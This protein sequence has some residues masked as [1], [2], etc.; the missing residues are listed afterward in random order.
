MSATRIK[1][2]DLLGQ[3]EWINSQSPVSIHDQRGRV[4]LLHFTTYSSIVC[5]HVMSDIN[6]LEKRYKD[7]LTVITIHSPKHPRERETNNVIN[8]VSRFNIKHPVINDSNHALWKKFRIKVWPSIIFID[9]EGYIVGVIKGEGRR[10]QLDGLIRQSMMMAEQKELYP[11][12]PLPLNAPPQPESELAFPGRIH[13]TGNRLFISDS[14]HNRVLETDITG[15]IVRAY[16]SENPG[17]L[18]GEGE[19]ALF[20]NPQGIVKLSDYLYVADTDNHA[21][22]RIHLQ[23]GDVTTLMGNGR[24]GIVTNQRFSDPASAQLNSPW[25]LAI[26]DGTLYI[27]MA[28]HHQ[29]WRWHLGMNQLE[30]FAGMSKEQLQ[31]GDPQL[32][33]FA[34][35]SGIAAGDHSLYIADAESSAI[36]TIRLPDGYVS[37]LVG[38]GLFDFGDRDGPNHVARL[39]HPLDVVYDQKRN[40]LWICDTYNNKLKYYRFNQ[41]DVGHLELSG[42]QEPGGLCL[43][44]DHLWVANTNAHEI[45]RLDLGSGTCITVPIHR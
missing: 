45:K 31:D 12:S 35:P 22:R 43:V 11:T 14:G 32:A 1:A 28:G 36:R 3:C 25:G 24:Q 44:D 42:L 26:T 21:L 16:G 10:Q 5:Q 40:M 18:D 23:S 20:R 30:P 41:H 2:P 13:A 37:T 6:Y 9:P 38:Q 29:V 39:Q 8:A 4:V 15:K 27:A 33:A 34:Q 19:E 17:F 7:K